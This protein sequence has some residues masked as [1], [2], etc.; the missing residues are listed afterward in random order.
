MLAVM[1]LE[2]ESNSLGRG[3]LEISVFQA[4]NPM[5]PNPQLLPQP[6]AAVFNAADWDVLAPAAGG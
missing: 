5:L 1:M 3:L 6:D 4:N 2:V